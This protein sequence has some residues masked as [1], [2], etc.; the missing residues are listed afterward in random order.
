[1]R[2]LKEET[3]ENTFS[4]SFAWPSILDKEMTTPR[5]H[6][7]NAVL[8]KMYQTIIVQQGEGPWARYLIGRDWPTK[9]KARWLRL[10]QNPSV[11]VFCP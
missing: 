7:L 10:V 9:T 1:M 8:N 6:Y 11:S 2:R 5:V 4:T 3:H